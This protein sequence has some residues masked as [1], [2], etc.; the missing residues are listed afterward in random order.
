MIEYFLFF[1]LGIF[2]L[3]F[4]SRYYCFKHKKEWRQFKLN[5]LKK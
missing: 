2:S 1:L 3:W 5:Y 4:I